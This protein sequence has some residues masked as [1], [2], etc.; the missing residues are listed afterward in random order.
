MPHFETHCDESYILFGKEYPEVHK[1]LDAYFGTPEEQ[2]WH[3][4]KRHHEEG[5]KECVKLFGED[6]G[7]VARQHIISDLKQD[8]WEEG[9]RFPKDEEDYIALEKF[10]LGSKRL[11]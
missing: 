10:L 11:W 6:A 2:F 7:T 5:I 4:H 9:M 8:G 3:R 1:W